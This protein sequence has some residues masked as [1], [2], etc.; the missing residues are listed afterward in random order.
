MNI[1]FVS[2]GSLPMP[3]VNG[4][5]AENL[6]QL[7][8]EEN[9]VE[10]RHRMVVF[11]CW[12]ERATLE[13]VKYKHT[14][15]RFV[16]RNG[17]IDRLLRFFSKLMIKLVK[18]NYALD[19]KRYAHMVLRI[20]KKEYSDFDY[21]ILENGM[22]MIR[23]LS[24]SKIPVIYHAHND[25]VGHG[26]FDEKDAE[27]CYGLI[28]ISDY[29][30]DCYKRL[31]GLNGKGIY[32]L[33]NCVDET[34]LIRNDEFRHKFRTERGIKD[35]DIVCVFAGRIHPTKGVL[36]LL[37]AFE[38]INRKDIYLLVVG[39]IDYNNNGMNAYSEK[40]ERIVKQLEARVICTGYIPY[41]QI[42]NYY[43]V[44][45]IGIVP[46]VWDEPGGRVLTEMQL[47]S[48]PLICTI[49]GGM[50]DYV[51]DE[52]CVVLSTEKLVDNIVESILKLADDRELRNEMSLKAYN[53]AKEFTRK[54]YYDCFCRIMDKI[55]E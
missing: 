18:K 20:I 16:K 15:Y 52:S 42:Q 37:Q 33:L 32:K 1:I 17:Y 3:P 45:D 29:I 4:G 30:S 40:C 47:M 51:S 34:K 50:S 49:T 28:T 7:L 54:M 48:L 35:S 26:A 31:Q 38:Q 14:E 41:A 8:I 27:K 21:I 23:E 53:K 25:W 43:S 9:E 12:D 19:K 39:G 55:N 44:A 5:A 22:Y 24:K 36:E 6:V 46:S 13:A 2:V 10:H 11:G